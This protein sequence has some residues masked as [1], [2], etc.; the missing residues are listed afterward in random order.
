MWLAVVRLVHRRGQL[1]LVG[2]G[3]A[4]AAAM[5]GV[6]SAGSLVSQERSLQ[7]HIAALAPSVRAMRLNSY[8]AAGQLAPYAALDRQARSLL[9]PIGTGR[10][11]VGTVLFRES[12]I[13][14][15]YVGLG[16]VDGLAA[17]V[18]VRSGRTPHRCRPER[19]EVLQ[20]RGSAPPPDV[21]GLHL[22]RVGRGDVASGALFG[23]AI[24]PAKNRLYDESLSAHYRRAGRYHQPAPPPLYLAEGVAVLARSPA[25]RRKFRSYGWVVPLR[26]ADVEPWSSSRLVAA[27]ER[28]RAGSQ[29]GA[30]AFE[31]RAPTEELRAAAA[32]VEVA[33]TRLLLLGGQGAALLLG[34]V[35]FAA[36]TLR[37]DADSS[38]RRLTWLGAPRWQAFLVVAAEAA[39][40]AVVAV[41][42]GSL[43]GGV[44]SLLGGARPEHLAHSL[45][46]AR[47]L[48]V[49]AGFAVAATL[50]LVVVLLVGRLRLGGLAF[51][52]LD[53]AALGALGAAALAVGRGG[54]DAASASRPGTAALLL[55]LPGLIAFAIAVATARLLAPCLLLFERVA[56]P[57]VVAL[58]LAALSLARRP[59]G[60][61]AAVAF[62]SVSAGLGLFAATYRSTLAAGQRD[63]A[64]FAVPADFVLREDLARLI[65]VRDVA[66]PAALATLPPGAR[67]TSVTRLSGSLSGGAAAV[68]GI[69]VLG[70]EPTTIAR[71]DG[72]RESWAA[73]DRP[74]LARRIDPG[75]VNLAGATVPR[76]ARALVLPVRVSGSSFSLSAV[77][78]GR[79]GI[80]ADV[81]L[82]VAEAGSRTLRAR[83]PAEAR[84]GRLVAL[85]FDPPPRIVERGADAGSAAEAVATLAPLGA[86][87]AR[88]A[89]VTDF[90]GWIGV[91]GARRDGTKPV[92]LTLAL[93]E[94]TT[95]YFRPRQ[96]SDDRTLPGIVSPRLS[97]LAGPS[98]VLGV[99]VAGVRVPVRAVA[100]AERFPG[101]GRATGDDFVVL[102]RDLLLV[103]LD[104]ADPGT[105][106]TNEV[107]VDAP[108]RLLPAVAARLRRPPFDVLSNESQR[109]RELELRR[110]PV[111]RAAL[112]MLSAAAAV[113]GALAVIGLLLAAVAQ[114]RDERGELFDLESQGATLR[115]LR[116]QVRLRVGAILV[117]G[118]AGAA[119]IGLALS[120]VVVRLILLTAGATAP[121]PPLVLSFDWPI[122]AAG[123]AALVVGVGVAVA[124]VTARAFRK[125]E[126]GR[127][128]EAPA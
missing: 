15:R 28:A 99:N 59:G 92:R 8:G 42:A 116:A 90:R 111:A 47:G 56:P 30:A 98:R 72:W 87:G 29:A 23:D 69:T 83:L 50:V 121:E 37:R 127:P 46:S 77:V 2:F 9:A 41:A 52:P 70:V 16:A 120:A 12:T 66:T 76:A 26:A 61:T 58:R 96:A 34:F 22:V 6:V 73:G 86:A 84:G 17:H 105:G 112:L 74:A 13:A 80:V 88:G 71:L 5:L 65:R 125:P 75:N 39:T 57:T 126:A 54:A 49:A 7:R 4:A 19:C 25:L 36:A 24:P 128:R 93:T 117:F 78:R 21:P 45:V 82:G 124:V 38:R 79:D 114:L 113:A 44:I 43:A 109:Q 14:G 31:L 40:V 91:S 63:Q 68:T 101:A 110:E 62:V 123:A 85:R 64:A 48:A 33:G 55:L 67:A 27:L 108:R 32:R 118:L 94:A 60:A 97:D 10:A 107:W 103:A 102:D 115:Q 20:L 3:V 51:S 119:L 11:P 53:V 18:V 95:T 104:T 106:L 122:V 1:A 35:A 81:P 100:V 89:G